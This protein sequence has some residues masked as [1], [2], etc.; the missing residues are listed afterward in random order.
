MGKTYKSYDLDQTFLLP[1][2]LREWLPGNHLAYFVADVVNALDLSKIEDSYGSGGQGQPP[3]HPAMMVAL[4][5]YA[6]CVGTPSS[7]KIERKTYEDIAFRVLAAGHHPD[8]D[9]IASFR[10]AHL[11]TLKDLFLQILLLCQ[12]AHLV[13]VGHISLDGTKMKANASKHKAMSYERMCR[14]ETELVHE[15][16]TLLAQAERTDH[17]EDRRYGKGKRADE[18]PEELAFREQRLKKIRE[19]KKALEERIRAEAEEGKRSQPAPK[20]RNQINFTDGESRIMKDSAT[21]EFIQGYN[22][23]CA[24]DTQ[25]Q[26]IVAADVTIETNDKKQIEPMVHR[27][28]SRNVS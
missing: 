26:I 27:R 20:P 19:A 22:A 17:E 5:F 12:E 25:S 14:R 2:S 8:H 16:E 4:L 9:T 6:Y 23:Q 10:R 1:P 15:I 18:L 13:T 3:Y 11:A 28:E 24:V 7:R 21:K